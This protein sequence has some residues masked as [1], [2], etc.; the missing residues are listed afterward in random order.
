MFYMLPNVNMISVHTTSSVSNVNLQEVV[1]MAKKDE[2]I[3]FNN[4][5]FQF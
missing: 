4:V 2:N 5:R 3:N 1:G